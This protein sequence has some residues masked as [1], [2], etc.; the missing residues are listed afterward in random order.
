METTEAWAGK[1]RDN[2]HIGDF[3][4]WKDHDA[5]E[6]AL[7]LN[8]KFPG[9]RL[10]LGHVLKTV[11]RQ[12]EAIEAY[13]ECIRL[14]PERANHVWSFDFVESRTHDGRSL[15]IMTLIDEHTRACPALKV[16][17]RINSFGVIETIA[18]AGSPPWFSVSVIARSACFDA[19]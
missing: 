8:P 7:E 16:A 11:G 15:R 9:A 13:R 19:V 1:L 14:R 18:D 17:R 2:R 12:E 5:Y 3:R 10:G 4:R 6:K